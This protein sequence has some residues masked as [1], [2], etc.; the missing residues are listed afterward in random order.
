MRTKTCVRYIEETILKGINNEELGNGCAAEEIIRELEKT[1]ELPKN[2]ITILYTNTCESCNEDNGKRLVFPSNNKNYICCECI[3]NTQQ[4]KFKE[5]LEY[6]KN[7]FAE[8]YPSK[9]IAS[10]KSSKKGSRLKQSKKDKNK[11]T[12]KTIDWES[13]KETLFIGEPKKLITLFLEIKRYLETNYEAENDE[14]NK[15]TKD[16]ATI[17]RIAYKNAHR[18]NVK[19]NLRHFGSTEFMYELVDKDSPK[20]YLSKT[21]M[22]DKLMCSQSLTIIKHEEDQEEIVKELYKL[23]RLNGYR[24]MLKTAIEMKNK[25][26]EQCISTIKRKYIE[27]SIEM[28]KNEFNRSKLFLTVDFIRVTKFCK[29]FKEIAE[30]DV[31]PTESLKKLILDIKAQRRHKKNYP[32]NKRDIDTG[33]FVCFNTVTK[34]RIEFVYCEICQEG[35]DVE[36]GMIRG[37]IAIEKGYY[38]QNCLQG[39][40]DN[41]KKCYYCQRSHMSLFKSYNNKYYHIFCS[42]MHNDW[43]LLSQLYPKAKETG[44]TCVYCK[45]KDGFIM[46]CACC[47]KHSFHYMCGYLNGLYFRVNEEEKNK[48]DDYIKNE[49]K[50]STEMLCYKC[51]KDKAKELILKSDNM[52][53]NLTI[54]NNKEKADQFNNM[55]MALVNRIRYYRVLNLFPE[56]N[57]KSSN[58][59]AKIS[60][61][62]GNEI[63]FSSLR[64]YLKENQ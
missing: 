40:I 30:F 42:F 31:D 26:I 18:N 10:I 28:Y 27:K 60:K 3:S 13:I 22:I 63:S 45:D 5:I 62:L 25:S 59:L 17:V 36:C 19:R 38:C 61:D 41:E 57:K 12:K 21:S 7:Y 48:L 9:E 55:L 2:F 37:V 33:C 49:L 8:I 15:K 52:T 56:E 14:S 24:I 43:S 44:L 58:N 11:K 35:V 4:D 54:P 39:Q 47:D 46:K 53:N 32:K 34:K 23:G 29:R 6:C 20:K 51:T 16:R 1:I 50:Y 64:D